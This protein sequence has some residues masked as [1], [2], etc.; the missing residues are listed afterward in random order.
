[1]FSGGEVSPTLALHT[2][3]A[4]RPPSPHSPPADDSY[5]VLASDG[6]FAEEARGGGGGLDNNTVAELCNAS[7]GSSCSA[8]AE[9]MS[10]A[11]QKVGA[12]LILFDAEGVRAWEY[13]M[14]EGGTHLIVWCVGGARLLNAS[15]LRDMLLVV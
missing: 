9:S 1:M 10:K 15:H 5:V 6:L 7:G 12:W 11:A 14:R 8:L 4:P 2:L 13:L 3:C